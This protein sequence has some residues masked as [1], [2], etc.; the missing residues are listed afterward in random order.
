MYSAEYPWLSLGGGSWETEVFILELHKGIP[1]LQTVKE[2]KYPCS[3]CERIL[4]SS[5]LMISVFGSGVYSP[6][7]QKTS[8]LIP[9]S[10][11]GIAGGKVIISQAF[12]RFL[13]FPSASLTVSMLR[14]Y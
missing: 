12:L 2:R 4:N 13:R 10:A 7:F 14:N 5:S 1:A 8:E 6:A 11:R 9:S 3:L